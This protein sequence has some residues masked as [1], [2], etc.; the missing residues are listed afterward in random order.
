MT[1]S[2]K[3]SIVTFCTS[4]IPTMTAARNDSSKRGRDMNQSSLVG[5]RAM[6]RIESFGQS[7]MQLAHR[8]QFALLIMVRGNSNTGQ[9]R[10]WPSP[11]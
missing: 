1:G 9:P 5:V 6:S 11:R 8:L 7:L 10:A 3:D 4:T 2:Q